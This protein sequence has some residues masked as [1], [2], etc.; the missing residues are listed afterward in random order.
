MIQLLWV[1][2]FG[3]KARALMKR[4]PRSRLGSMNVVS[5]RRLVVW[6]VMTAVVG[7]SA[8]LVF[9]PAGGVGPRVSAASNARLE[10]VP[11]LILWAW[12]RREDLSYL[13]SR[14]AG[15][16]FLAA[17]ISLSGDKWTVRPRLEPLET[18]PDTYLMATVRIE[19][20]HHRSLAPPQTLARDL[21]AEILNR[22]QGL[23]ASG[24][25]I[26]FD[27][28]ASERP[29]YMDL[30]SELRRRLPA[31][32]PLSMTAL[33]SWCEGDPWVAELPVDE[34]VPMLFR[35]GPDGKKIL[36]DIRDGQDFGPEV[37]RDGIGISTDEYVLPIFTVRRMYVFNPAPWTRAALESVQ[38]KVRLP[39]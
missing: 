30:L 14:R 5:L 1:C 18:P 33:A 8:V 39:Q 24:V 28:K 7:L 34:A 27:A 29:F 19:V 2:D 4:R 38:R 17:T 23:G 37:C 25:Q 21:A 35:M 26:D 36:G 12:E 10:K 22:A 31:T 6:G 3:D 16:A 32:M 9:A 11:R 13:D 15:V 20:D